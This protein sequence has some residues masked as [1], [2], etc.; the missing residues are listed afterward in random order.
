MGHF[1]ARISGWENSD[2]FFPGSENFHFDFV[3]VRVCELVKNLLKYC[4]ERIKLLT[5]RFSD[6][7][8][9]VLFHRNPSSTLKLFMGQ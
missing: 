7:S 5:G 3:T 2:A 1:K 9:S 4:T 8:Q 6:L